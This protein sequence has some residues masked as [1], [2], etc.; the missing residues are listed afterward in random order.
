MQLKKITEGVN[1][2]SIDGSD[3]IDISGITCDSRK[4]GRGF[5]FVA[6][7][8]NNLDGNKFIKDA[9]ENGAICII[10]ESKPQD[11]YNVTTVT[12]K[13]I[14]AAYAALCANFYG[15]PS[16]ELKII[17]ITGTNGKTTTAYLIESLLKKANYKCGRIGTIDYS[18]GSRAFPALNTTPDAGILQALFKEMLDDKT[19]YC[20][21]EVSSHS[22]HQGRVD[23]IKFHSAVFTNLSKEHLDYHKTPEEYFLS[24]KKL[25]DGLTEKDYAVINMGNI[26]GTILMPAVKSKTITY[27]FNKNAKIRAKDEVISLKGSE[28]FLI[29]PKGEARISTSL[30]GRYN[31]YN[32]LAAVSVAQEEGVDLNKI[33]E[34]IAEFDPPPGRLELVNPRGDFYVYVDFAHTDDALRKVLASLSVLTKGRIITVFGCG[35]DRDKTKRPRMG[36]IASRLSDFVI[37]TSDN[38][39]SEDPIDIIEQIKQG[40]LPD[41][42]DYLAIEDREKAIKEAIKMAK[43]DDIVLIAGKGHETSQIYKDKTIAFDD[44]EIA[45]QALG[46]KK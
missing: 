39:R 43:K 19:D 45:R 15:N 22:L 11:K 3:E 42:K 21:M 24:K 14:R 36:R 38:P 4:V 31:I 13:D 27:G 32:I 8:G 26:Y 5:A 30:V 35:G 12:F 29:T 20:V 28:F 23:S 44:R 10:S 2:E 34:A 37:I 9:V 46:I 25:F 33:K 7:K 18:T 17:G 6:I 16:R 40:M 41:F 1:V